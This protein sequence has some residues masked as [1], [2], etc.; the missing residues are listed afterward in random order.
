MPVSFEFSLI[1]NPNTLIPAAF[2]AGLKCL[3][4]FCM[5]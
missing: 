1:L 4:G 2:A 3:L 5:V